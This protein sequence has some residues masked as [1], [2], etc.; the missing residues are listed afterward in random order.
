MEQEILKGNF[1]KGNFNKGKEILTVIATIVGSIVVIAGGWSFYQSNFYRPTK[2][3]KVIS[4]DYTK[5]IAQIQFKKETINLL[6]STVWYLTGQW[7][8]G[9]GYTTDENGNTVYNSIDI[10]QSGM[11]Y[12]YLDMRKA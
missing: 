9:F 7:G 4:V 1:N 5:G 6:G 3:L 12:D 10:I 8:I 11:V 2:D